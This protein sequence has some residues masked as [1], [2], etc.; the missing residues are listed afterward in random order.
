[1][2]TR[3][4]IKKP[5]GP[6][7]LLKE[8]IVFL[9]EFFAEFKS[10]GTCFPSSKWAADA[11]TRPIQG[12]R[13]AQNILELGPG[14]GSVTIKIL[15]EMQEGDRLTIC[16]INPRFMQALKK[17][18][19]ENE[20]Y[21]KHR[22]KV[23]FFEG[24]VQS[25]PVEGKFNTIVCALPFLNFDLKTIQEIFARLKEVSLPDTVMTYYEYIGLKEIRRIVSSAE[26]KQL[27]R[28]S[29]DFF[30]EVFEKHQMHR[31]KVWRNLLPIYIYKLEKMA[32]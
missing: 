3:K 2:E 6:V 10:T 27:I 4:T 22:D 1:V 26:K 31:S 24:P 7:S 23:T 21:Q 13:P 16:E 9:R 15:E 5:N 20:D 14:T 29:E 11:L 17:M 19:L 8:Q 25:L 12:E 18:L 30:E 32:A 28:E